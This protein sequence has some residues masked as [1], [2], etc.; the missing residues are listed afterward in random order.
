MHTRPLM[1]RVIFQQALGPPGVPPSLTA[2]AV[3]LDRAQRATGASIPSL[4]TSIAA[5][6]RCRALESNDAETEITSIRR[7]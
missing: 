1:T 2:R 5:S 4:A 6:K 3:S 7:G